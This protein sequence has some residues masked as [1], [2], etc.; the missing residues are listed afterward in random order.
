M[1]SRTWTAL[2]K[3]AAAGLLAAA[4]STAALAQSWKDS[5]YT[6]TIAA[7]G[8]VSSVV[9]MGSGRLFAI[10]MPSVWT[11]AN[12][13]FQASQDGITYS[14][15]FDSTGTEV[16]FT[17]AASQYIINAVPVEWIGVRYIKV[18]SGTSGTPVT[19]SAAAALVIITVPF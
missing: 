17:A 19:Q 1:M 18:R 13:T 3:T 2:L 8:T 16:T 7:S 14:N 11:A 6:A 4:L 9:D 10:V 15:M 5:Q 12:L